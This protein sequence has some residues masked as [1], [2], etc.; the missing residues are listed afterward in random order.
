MVSSARLIIASVLLILCAVAS[1]SPQT[2]PEKTTN[3]N[4]TGKVT[5]K[6]KG[7]AGV[8]VVA[9]ERDSENYRT[10]PRYRGT[11]D[12]TGSY[13][14]TNIPPGTYTITPAAP[15]LA[16]DKEITSNAIVV[17]EGET[18]EDVDF[19][20]VPGGVITGKVTDADGRPLID[21][22]ISLM[23]VD[24]VVINVRN[25]DNIRTDDRGIYRA[26]GLREGKYKVSVGQTG[27]LPGNAIASYSETYYPSVTDAEKATVIEVTE[28]SEITNIDIV[29]G[30]ALPT[31][32]VRGRIL[33]A[34]T[35]KPI[36]NVKYGVYRSHGD[37]GGASSVGRNVTNVNGEF[38][39]DNVQP[40][41]YSVFI[42]P[43]ES[44]VRA[45]SVSFEVLDHDIADLVIRAGKS[46]SLSGVVVF[47]GVGEIKP[48]SLMINAWA[49]SPQRQFTGNMPQAVNPD[50]SFRITGLRKGFMRFTFHS[51]EM[52]DTRQLA[53][54]RVERDGAVQPQ[55]VFIDDGEQVTGVRL[56]VK[57]LTGAIHGQIRIENDEPL[58]VSRISVWINFTDPARQGP[59]Y[60]TS[61]SSPQLDSRKRFVVEHLAPGTYEVNV[62]VF[63]PGRMD[64]TRVY[65]QEVAVMDNA[66]SDVTIT[67]KKP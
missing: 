24:A 61:G 31:F 23:P 26:Y 2:T 43:E 49:Q 67:I 58:P 13:R 55:G 1:A 53:L 5:L 11:T 60:F 45:D 25:T 42:V 35:G 63:E 10:R 52:N 66:V 30:R 12:Q 34:E 28:G 4:I 37:S 51:R 59:S 47:E 62:A 7:V 57:Y 22:Y 15:S 33:D 9:E 27:F 29:L 17:S 8:M 39:F 46:A 6:N 3:G 14:I 16:F 48:N 54:L 40:G 20:M 64:T 19:S 50:G 36:P 21:A 41:K 38:M 65:K 18:I 44:G 56:V 32:K